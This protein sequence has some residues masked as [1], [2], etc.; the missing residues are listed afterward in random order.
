MKS[1][2]W[3]KLFVLC[4]LLI[5]LLPNLVVEAKT[6]SVLGVSTVY[7]DRRTT[8]EL[9]VFL[10]SDEKIGSGSFDVVYDQTALSNVK[11]SVGS[12]INGSLHAVHA[13]NAGTV[14]MAWADVESKTV[15]G[16][17]LTFTARLDKNGETVPLKLENVHLYREDGTE[18]DMQIVDG[19]VKPFSGKDET[20]GSKVKNDKVWTVTL[21]EPFNPATLNANAVK[22][23]RGT[24]EIAVDVQVKDGKT[25][26]VTPKV[27]YPRGKYVLEI[28]EQI[29]SEKGTKLKEP[30]RLEFTV[31]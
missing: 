31:E 7:E 11:V 15:K 17:M 13:D 19:E 26:T 1:K 14:S 20:H 24:T 3:T 27:N 2:K 4:S 28:S 22:V 8:V 29:Y 18:I 5:L 16:T 9:S 23:M 25:F 21:S 30:R 12:S 10:Q 6:T